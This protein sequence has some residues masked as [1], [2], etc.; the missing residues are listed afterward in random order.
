ML[1][2]YRRSNP[3]R[4]SEEDLYA[5]DTRSKEMMEKPD[6]GF[7]IMA[8]YLRSLYGRELD[9]LPQDRE[10]MGYQDKGEYQQS[11]NRSSSKE[12]M[13][14]SSCK[15]PDEYDKVTFDDHEDDVIDIVKDCDALRWSTLGAIPK[16]W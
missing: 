2:A 16:G 6:V 9:K 7:D 4:W 12:A 1:G 13:Y 14:G 8:H 11:L 3:Y 10:P 15:Q 5:D